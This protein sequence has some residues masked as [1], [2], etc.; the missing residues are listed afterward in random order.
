MRTRIYLL[1]MIS[2]FS[3]AT[4]VNAQSIGYRELVE[5]DSLLMDGLAAYD[6]TIRKDI[7]TVSLY[8]EL[9]VKMDE[10]KDNSG[11]AFQNILKPYKRDVQEGLYDLTRYPD[12]I[13]DLV[14]GGKKSKKEVELLAMI[15]PEDIH[16]SC[17][18]YGSTEYDALYAIHRLNQKNKKDFN[19]MLSTYDE[20][21]QKSMKRMLEY[22]EVLSTMSDNLE[23][24]R[25]VGQAYREDPKALEADLET[26]YLEI[27]EQKR[28]ELADYKA[29][30]EQ[31]DQAMAEMVEA[32]QQYTEET[33]N[34]NV[35]QPV[36]TVTEVV[37]VHHYSY[38]YGYPTWYSSPYWRPYPWYYHTGFYYGPGGGMVFIGMPSY[39]YVGW[40]FHRYPNRYPHLAYHYCRHSYRHPYS[41]YD[42]N[43]TVR[44]NISDNRQVDRRQLRQIDSRRDNVLSSSGR[45]KNDRVA[46]RETRPTTRQSTREVSN[47]SRQATT[48]QGNQSSRQATTR[49]S[50]QATSR[51][52]TTR[53]SQ[54]TRQSS[55]TQSNRSNQNTTRQSQQSNTRSNQNS[56]RTTTSPMNYNN[57]RS[58]ESFRS[59]MSTPRST[60][61]ARN[62]G[63]GGRSGGGRR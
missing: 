25:L 55:N 50:N 2:F 5:E 35:A 57:Y 14:E 4:L 47:N 29:Q 34:G 37:Y 20:S 22:P 38:W 59:N 51:E 19:N 44:R 54:S 42:F 8:P 60:S 30:L 16:E 63:G 33:G 9:F 41:R 18:K 10:L 26:R 1:V 53:Q 39:W 31:D 49:Q 32:A 11:S 15:Y 28:K 23:M 46:S 61:P 12:L 52:A 13:A 40:Q 6:L 24:V 7:L 45:V 17:K 43:R 58:N 36:E 56:N 62:S 3:A 21:L 48:R 27:N